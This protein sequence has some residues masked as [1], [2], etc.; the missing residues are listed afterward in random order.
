MVEIKIIPFENAVA[1]G[2]ALE[3][4]GTCR[5]HVNGS[6]LTAAIT[7]PGGKVIYASAVEVFEAQK[8]GEADTWVARFAGLTDTPDGKAATL[9]V[10]LAILESGKVVMEPSDDLEFEIKNKPDTIIASRTQG[11]ASPRASAPS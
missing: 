5:G 11:V 6:R 10:K 1:E 7:Y 3:V 4:K 8:E 9:V 2:G